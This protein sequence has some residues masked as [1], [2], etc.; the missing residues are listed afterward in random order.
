MAQ[1]GVRPKNTPSP[2]KNLLGQECF[3]A[4]LAPTTAL[5]A[6]IRPVGASFHSGLCCRE[7][8]LCYNTIGRHLPLDTAESGSQLALPGGNA[9]ADCASGFENRQCLN[10]FRLEKRFHFCLKLCLNS[11]HIS[12]HL[13]GWRLTSSSPPQA[14]QCRTSQLT[15]C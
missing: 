8:T 13:W 14:Q 1:A 12:R 6:W 2:P 10:V 15:L 4:A 11:P 9:V 7:G 5:E 3:L